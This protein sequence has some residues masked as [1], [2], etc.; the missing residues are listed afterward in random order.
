MVVDRIKASSGL[1]KTL[2]GL[3]LMV[4][5]LATASPAMA[6]GTSM[7]ETIRG[8]NDAFEAEDYQTAYDLYSRAYAELPEPTI[9]YRMGQAAEQ[10]GMY[11]EAIEHYTTYLDEGQDIEFIGRIAEVVPM[12][13]EKVPAMLEIASVPAG[14]T[15]VGVDEAGVETELGQ[16]PATVDVGPGPVTV[17]LRAQGYEEVIWQEDAQAEGSYAWSPEMVAEPVAMVVE[18]DLEVRESGGSLGAWGWTTAGLGVAAL[19]T[20]GV[21]TLLQQS[22]TESVNSYDKRAIGATRDE[23]EGYKNDANGYFETARV[24]YIAGGVLTAA[25]LGMI[26]YQA[27]QGDTTEEQALS[28]EGG[29]SSDGG[30]VGLRGRF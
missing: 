18:D 30:F 24:T 22:A 17:V 4:C 6:Q 5:A 12:L 9:L 27:T 28:F 7:L 23:L 19:A 13:R 2:L 29:V 16:T 21:F 1:M 26:I 20:G 14:A 3:C 10:L 11:R 25:G 8:A 15:I